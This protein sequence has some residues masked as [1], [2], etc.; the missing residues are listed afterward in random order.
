M[1]RALR[2]ARR[3]WRAHQHIFFDS[4][5]LVVGTAAL[6]GAR[7]IY[8][9]LDV[10]P[11]GG[12]RR[13]V[14]RGAARRAAALVV[15]E[16]AK[17]EVWPAR[18][19]R[20]FVVRNALPLHVANDI[21]QRR[22]RRAEFLSAQG[23]DPG[24][25][26]LV[27][28]GGVA[29]DFGLMLECAAMAFLDEDVHLALVGTREAGAPSSTDRRVHT[30]GGADEESWR[31][32][33]AMA[34]AGLA[35][36]TPTPKGRADPLARWNTPASWN[37]LYWYLA[38]GLPVVLGGHPELRAFGEESDSAVLVSDVRA[39]SLAEGV[40]QALA[41]SADLAAAARHVFRSR[42]NFEKESEPLRRFLEGLGT[43]E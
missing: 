15:S 25:R 37:R 13:A 30:L 39:E 4:R 21:D 35:L 41:R 16:P 8:Y 10:L 43:P 26:V 2:A 18:A 38:A 14:E 36:W 5:S 17:L 20:S 12:I 9:C 27:H 22:S 3:R 7:R 31:D 33:L 28:A 40:R 23:I 1:Y 42:F 32:W 24:A 29:A 34:S 19:D 11:A 6:P